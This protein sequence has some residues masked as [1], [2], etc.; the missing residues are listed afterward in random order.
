MVVKEPSGYAES[1]LHY[2]VPVGPR[3]SK[4]KVC[5]GAIAHVFVD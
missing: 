5:Q 2:L 1:N 4:Q 3:V